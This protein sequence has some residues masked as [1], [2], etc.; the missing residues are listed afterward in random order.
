[1]LEHNFIL[2]TDSYKAGHFRQYPPETQQLFGYMES[3][4]GHYDQTLFFGLQYLLKKYFSK[5]ITLDDIVEASNFFAHHGE[6]FPAEGWKH[7]LKKH[8]GFMPVRIRAVP[9]GT[10][11]PNHNVILTVEGTDPKVP[12]IVGWIE[13]QIMRLW[14]PITVATRSWEC[15]RIIL[16]YLKETADDPWSELL[17]KL[18]DFGS[19]G[20]SSAESAGIGGMSHLVN[21]LGSDTIEGVRYAN[22]Y[23]GCKTGMAGVSI[24]AMTPWRALDI[25]IARA[26][27]RSGGTALPVCTLP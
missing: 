9:E 2:D 8:G 16:K 1:M 19:R 23:Y 17:Y 14:Y 12:W 6:P 22:H 5:P 20:V 21:F 15:K 13:T 3:R 27:A 4:G 25:S 18:H 24:P 10:L 11:V 7:I 26:F